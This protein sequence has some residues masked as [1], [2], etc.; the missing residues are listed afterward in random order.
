MFWG[1]TY[2]ASRALLANDNKSVQAINRWAATLILSAFIA[3]GFSTGIVK[4]FKLVLNLNSTE[5]L[6]AMILLVISHALAAVI[7]A[8]FLW[9][10]MKEIARNAT[11]GYY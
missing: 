8:K 6:L 10:A 7:A 4:A 11:K 1:S 9:T 5:A 3:I 2:L